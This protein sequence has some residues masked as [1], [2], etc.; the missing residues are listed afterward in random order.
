[1]DRD[2]RDRPPG[3]A[4]DTQMLGHDE[5]LETMTERGS[6]EVAVDLMRMALAL[7]DRARESASAGRLQSALDLLEQKRSGRVP[8]RPIP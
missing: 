1:M 3:A 2:P 7:L 5:A 8:K 4:R 6:R